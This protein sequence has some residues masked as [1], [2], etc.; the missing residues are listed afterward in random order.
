MRTKLG[1]LARPEPRRSLF[2]ARY[3]N[4]DSLTVTVFAFRKD[5]AYLDNTE[6]FRSG[7][8]IFAVYWR[9][10]DGIPTFQVD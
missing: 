2:L 10:H 6:F 7:R 9:Q 5:R 8:Y 3:N 1:A 4:P